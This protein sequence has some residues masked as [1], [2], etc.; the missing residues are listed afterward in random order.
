MSFSCVVPML[1][2]QVSTLRSVK[3]QCE[4]PAEDIFAMGDEIFLE[5]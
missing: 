5:T 2:E 3:S 1:L 4:L